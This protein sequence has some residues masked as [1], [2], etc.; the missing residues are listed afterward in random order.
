MPLPPKKVGHE[1]EKLFLG[2]GIAD[3]Y[4]KLL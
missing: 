2:G 4:G 3:I 1:S